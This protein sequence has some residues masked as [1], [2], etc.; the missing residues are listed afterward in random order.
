[1]VEFLMF[2]GV[3]GLVDDFVCWVCDLY[4]IVNGCDYSEWNL[5]I[6]Y[7]LLVIYSDEFELMCK[8]KVLCKMVL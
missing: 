1:M 2:F 8:G 6:D 7:Y 4:G 3:Y 5:R